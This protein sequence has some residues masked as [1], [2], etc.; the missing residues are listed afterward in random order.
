MPKPDKPEKPVAT[1]LPAP[2]VVPKPEKP[3]KP[4]KPEHPKL[5]FLKPYK[6]IQLIL[7]YDSAIPGLGQMPEEEKTERILKC[8]AHDI[9][10]GRLVEQ[11]TTVQY[12]LTDIPE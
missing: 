10:A 2:I 12:N 11:N 4:V 7:E 5:A 3:E 1:E 6:R 9:L 8:L